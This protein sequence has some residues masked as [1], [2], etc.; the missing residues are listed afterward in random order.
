MPQQAPPFR[1]EPAASRRASEL[2]YHSR[3]C[4]VCRHPKREEIEQAL[5]D[6]DCISSITTEY[7]LPGRAALYRHAYAV[8]LF[9]HRNRGL[10]G[11]LARI[12]SKASVVEPDAM[13]IVRAV[14]LYA[15][16]N[17]DGQLI[18]P[19]SRVRS[20]REPQS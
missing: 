13:T 12:I 2:S 11:A 9:A 5:L 4:S 10:R 6:W 20:S 7:K 17:D 19:A 18:A 15:R 8:G 3:K 14:E 16:L 1:R